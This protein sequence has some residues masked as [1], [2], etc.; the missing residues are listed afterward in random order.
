MEFNTWLEQQYL[1]WEASTGHRQS[2]QNFAN[3]LGISNSLLSHYLSGSRKPAAKFLEKIADKLGD[4]AYDVL[5][6]PRPDPIL[7]EIIQTWG[8]LSPA[9]KSAI[10]KILHE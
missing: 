6:R 5:E 3:Y 4:E 7:R 1:H 9:Q 8:A 10:Q 2:L